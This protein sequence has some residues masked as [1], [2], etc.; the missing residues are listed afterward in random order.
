MGAKERLN[1]SSASSTTA[2]SEG[3]ASLS[4]W[5]DTSSTKDECDS[6]WTEV[7]DTGEDAINSLGKKKRVRGTKRKNGWSRRRQANYWRNVRESTPE[8]WPDSGVPSGS[9]GIRDPTPERWLVWQ[10]QGC[11]EMGAP[12]LQLS[13]QIAVC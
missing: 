9:A 12:D 3:A 2:E 1:F 5:T 7:S 13:R 11:V 10:R 8:R 4:D 6:E